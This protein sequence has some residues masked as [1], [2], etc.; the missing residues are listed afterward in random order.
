MRTVKTLDLSRDAAAEEY[1]DAGMILAEDPSVTDAEQEAAIGRL[2]RLAQDVPV[3]FIVKGRVKRL[4]DIK[5]YLY[6]GAKRV[7]LTEEQRHVY[8]EAAARFGADRLIFDLSEIPEWEA[9]FRWEDLKTN[10]DGLVPVVV[11]DYR[12][13]EV[14]MLAYM[15]Q[16]AYEQTIRTGRMTYF[17]RSR[18]ELWLKG[19]T[20]GHF[21]Y[22]KSLEIDCDNDT[23]LARVAQLG[24]AC[25]TGNRTC[26]YRSILKEE[27]PEKDPYTI[28]KEVYDVIEDRKLHPREGSY[29]NYLFDKGI[30]K[31][32]K[33]VGEEAAEII[34]AAKNPN[35]EEVIYEMS[36]FLY[37]AMVLMSEKGITWEQVTEELSRR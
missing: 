5:K 31:I 21:Q 26:F 10:S 24:A 23:I 36:D 15:N 20:S 1:L 28:L 14:L 37:H 27:Y 11:Q 18:R 9:A 12:T 17:S 13:G 2:I 6:A 32:L 29:T 7:L 34:I 33:K 30:D 22:V 4:E 3:P 35:P 16:E 8:D 25:H 19:E